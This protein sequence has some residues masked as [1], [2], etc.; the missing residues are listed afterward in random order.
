ML[1]DTIM[2]VDG[3]AEMLGA[4]ENVTILAPSNEAFQAFMDSPMAQA[5]MTE[6]GQIDP[7]AIQVCC[8]LRLDTQSLTPS[9]LGCSDVPRPQWHIPSFCRHRHARLHSH[10]AQQLRLRQRH[11]WSSRPGRYARGQCSHLL[12][13]FEQRD[14]DNSRTF[15]LWSSPSLHRSQDYRTKTSLEVS[16]TSSTAS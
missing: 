13:P 12:W 6:D 15:S 1:T 14:R 7:V 10:H 2:G 8:T 16:F 11:W 4:A 5:L 9:A 3:L